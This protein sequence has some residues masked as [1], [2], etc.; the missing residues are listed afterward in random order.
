MSMQLVLMVNCYLKLVLGLADTNPN[1][2]F[3]FEEQIHQKSVYKNTTSEFTT[4]EKLD[5]L[6]NVTLEEV[7][8]LY[9]EIFNLGQGSV[10]VTGPFKQHPELKQQIFNLSGSVSSSITLE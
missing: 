4:Q 6:S 3:L 10:T 2:L 9:N 1:Q 5:S 8:Q 7:K